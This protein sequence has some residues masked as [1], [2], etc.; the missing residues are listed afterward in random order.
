[1]SKIKTIEEYSLEIVHEFPELK[2]DRQIL[3][4]SLILKAM[5]ELVDSC[6]DELS[7]HFKWTSPLGYQYEEPNCSIIGWK[8]QVKDNG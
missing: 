5:H 3:L 4:D 6:P 8:K 7:L 2:T 1:M